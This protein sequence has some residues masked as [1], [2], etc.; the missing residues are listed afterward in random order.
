MKYLNLRQ[1]GITL[2]EVMVAI[3]IIASIVVAV[4]FSVTAYVDAR[5]ELLS[6]AK[7]VYLAE[8]GYEI[9]RAIRDNDWNV[10]DVLT[11]GTTHYLSVS[12]TSINVSTTPEVIDGNFYRS[13]VLSRVY[14]NSNDDIT[15][16]T[17]SGSYVDP[18]ILE[19]KI[20]VFG[21]TGTS[22]LTGILSNLHNI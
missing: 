3:S 14:R 11:I 19:V 2:V 6:D 1:S 4:G 8:E 13:F 5:S 17:A 22:S 10:I 9:L 20:S 7:S 16:S 18:E 12:T 21:P 15:T